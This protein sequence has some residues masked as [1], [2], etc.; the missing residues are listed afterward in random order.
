MLTVRS[1]A[2]GYQRSAKQD[3]PDASSV[4]GCSGGAIGTLG[5]FGEGIG[6]VGCSVGTAG[7]SGEGTGRRG[8]RHGGW[9]GSRAGWDCSISFACSYTV[10]Y[11]VLS[12]YGVDSACARG[13]QGGDHHTSCSGRNT[14]YGHQADETDND[15]LYGWTAMQ[16]YYREGST[17]WRTAMFRDHHHRLLPPPCDSAHLGTSA[18]ASRVHAHL[19]HSRSRTP[20]QHVDAARAC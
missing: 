16:K 9:M 6:T 14:D 15:I 1:R 7:C 2:G 20:A 4:L 8:C 11:L 12:T 5:C 17:S 19:R 18:P 10:I 13:S 3:A